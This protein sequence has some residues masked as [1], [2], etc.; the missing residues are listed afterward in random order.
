MPVV[1]YE[2]KNKIAYITLNRPEKRNAMNLEL[3]EELKTIWTDF[4]DDENLWAAIL[5]G[6]GE[7]FCAGVDILRSKDSLDPVTGER[8]ALALEATP[9]VYN[10]WKPIIAALHGYVLGGGW[11]LALNCDIRIAAENTLFGIPEG[12]WGRPITFALPLLRE[13][14]TT[15]A[16]EVLLTGNTI[17]AQRAYQLSLVNEVVP[18]GQIIKQASDWAERICEISPLLTRVTK[19]A[20]QL[21]RDLNSS[22]MM[23]LSKSLFEP[24]RKTNDFE[25]GRKAFAEKRKPQWKAK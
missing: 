19:K 20:I 23:T 18:C 21:G 9:T 24:L 22:D 5:S 8:R 25:E 11:W 13:I 15:I 1:L 12:R 2:K 7:A 3:V 6:A 16:R 10:V 14:P 17:T 4:R